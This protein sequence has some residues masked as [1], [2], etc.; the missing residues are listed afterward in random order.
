MVG[1]CC[2]GRVWQVALIH[3]LCAYANIPLGRKNLKRL[4]LGQHSATLLGMDDTTEVSMQRRVW[5][6]DC[7]ASTLLLAAHAVDTTHTHDC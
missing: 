5:K 3:Y 6:T 1:L 4:T 2:F 7:T